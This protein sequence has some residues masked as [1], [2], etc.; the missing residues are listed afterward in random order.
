MGGYVFISLYE[1]PTL[2][3][4]F[5]LPAVMKGVTGRTVPDSTMDELVREDILDLIDDTHQSVILNVQLDNG[6]GFQALG[7]DLGMFVFQPADSP[8]YAYFILPLRISLSP[9]IRET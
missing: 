9:L 2:Q 1:G 8:N 7:N 4:P 5:G 3:F 6:F